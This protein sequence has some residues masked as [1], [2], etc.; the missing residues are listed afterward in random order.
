MATTFRPNDTVGRGDLDIFLTDGS[1]HPTNAV[2]ITYALYFVDPTTLAEVL[3]G[4]SARVPLNPT[5]GEYYASLIVPQ[6]ATAGT[7]HIRWT[8]R[9]SLIQPLTVVV[10]TFTVVIPSII[11]T[12]PY[13]LN[14]RSMV[15][16][17]RM[18]LR[19]QNPDKFYHFRPPEWEGKVG[20]YNRVFGQIWEDAELKEYIERAIDWFDMA[21][22][23]TA[24]RSINNLVQSRPEWRTAVLWG[25]I[26][27]A[28][29]ALAMNWV[30]DEFDYSIGGVSL[31]LEK[32][33]K[34]ESLKQNAEGQFDKGTEAKARTVK[35]IR[36]LQQP[37]F[38]VGIRS[39]FGPNV[40]RGVLSPRNFVVIPLIML[41]YSV[42][43]TILP[44]IS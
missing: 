26:V 5:V 13:S 17:L 31:T 7:Y 11:V 33:S 42:I 29:F 27:H 41:G 24:L 12:D 3:V 28:C 6:G 23:N 2:E 16:K 37:R 44:A 10:M 39:S 14:E 36:G 38:G 22:P 40:G 30:Q 18:L 35:Y 20:Q 32:S 9:Q 4:P 1:G 21:P 25:A 15:D 43:Q 19:D 8:F 34:F